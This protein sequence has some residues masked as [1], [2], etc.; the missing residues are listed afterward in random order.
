M[1]DRRRNRASGMRLTEKMSRQLRTKHNNTRTERVDRCLRYSWGET[2]SLCDQIKQQKNQPK[3]CTGKKKKTPAGHMVSFLKHALIPAF[4][5][6]SWQRVEEAEEKECLANDSQIYSTCS[7]KWRLKKV[8]TAQ[9]I[10][11]RT[12][13]LRGIDKSWLHTCKWKLKLSMIK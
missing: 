6:V 7:L 10:K 4:I 12:L 8:G 11:R 5:A 2:D 1:L 9:E 3:R 13:Q